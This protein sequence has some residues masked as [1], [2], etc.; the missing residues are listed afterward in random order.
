MSGQIDEKRRA[1]ER[2]RVAY[3][4]ITRA[5]RSLT[6]ATGKV[7]RNDKSLTAHWSALTLPGVEVR[8]V[9]V[10]RTDVPRASAWVRVTRAFATAPAQVGGW[11]VVSPSATAQNLSKSV[12]ESLV[13]RVS[14][15][16][17]LH[18]GGPLQAM[19][20]V[21]H[22]TQTDRGDLVHGW[23]ANGGLEQ[24][25]ILQQAI[26]YLQQR[27]QS[28]DLAVAQW[29]LGLSQELAKRQPELF[30]I[31][32]EIKAIRRHEWPLLGVDGDRLYSGQM[33]LLLERPNGEL[34][35]IDFK[36]WNFLTK[37]DWVK[38]GNLHEYVPQL[39]AYRAGVQGT[40]RK[41]SKL[42]LLYAGQWSW[43]GW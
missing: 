37:S 29:L 1:E 33:D 28:S 17:E 40:G 24:V 35:I 34:W 15:A 7:E 25:P 13:A 4:A 3:V 10:A 39:E 16:A 43:I 5:K 6:L 31:L 26:D 30:A 9:A 12:A 23:M 8:A 19:V 32:S 42:V 14:A 11:K 36:G 38:Q 20:A 22:M 18:L 2:L 21:Q 27:W 41:V